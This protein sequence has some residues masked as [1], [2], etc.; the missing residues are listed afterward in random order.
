VSDFDVQRWPVGDDG[1]DATLL[2]EL[3]AA[4]VAHDPPP[5]TLEAAARDAFGLGRLSDELLA[6]VQDTDLEHAGARGVSEPRMLSFAN[7][8]LSAD[9][10][11]ADTGSGCTVRGMVA[12]PVQ[13]VLLQTPEEEHA[14]VLDDAGRFRGTTVA[15]R[16]VR[17]L[18]HTGSGRRMATGW[19]L[20]G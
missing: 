12:G 10:E 11:V 17:L 14:V 8:E 20:I 7:D 4:V 18:L 13:A 15:G 6:L 19:V 3:Q 5:P 2:A 16:M 9:I 1:G